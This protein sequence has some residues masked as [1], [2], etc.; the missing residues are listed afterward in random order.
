MRTRLQIMQNEYSSNVKK[1]DYLHGLIQIMIL[2][3]CDPVEAKLKY[4][5]QIQQEAD[6]K[7]SPDYALEKAVEPIYRVLSQGR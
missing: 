7:S 1:K 5:Q 3:D 4:D 6:Y 2:N